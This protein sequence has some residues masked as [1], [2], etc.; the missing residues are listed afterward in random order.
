MPSLARPGSPADDLPLLAVE[1]DHFVTLDGRVGRALACTGLN[2][3][4]QS[5]AA[6]DATAGAFA[7]LL[8]FLPQG[9]RLQ[10][11]AINR[12]LRGADWVAEHL[13]QYRPPAALGDYVRAL[14]AAYE[15][16]LAGRSVPDL[17]FYA[18]LTLPGAPAPRGPLARRFRRRRLLGRDRERHARA[19][20]E[21]ARAAAALEHAFA[22]LGIVAAP[23]GR[24][25]TLDL[26]WSCANPTWSGDAAAPRAVA[27][28]DLRT[29]RERLAQSRLVRRPEWLRLD[30]GYE[31]TL[32]LRALPDETF[33]GWLGQLLATGV[34]FR[35]ALHV[36]P[37]QKS[38]ERAA[39]GRTLR[40]RH[41]ILAERTRQG[42]SPDIEQ[43]EAYEEGRALLRELASTDLRTFRMAVFVTV[44]A[45][46]P[47]ALAA[48][49]GQV[50]RALGDAGGTSIDRCPLWQDRA[51]RA[52]LPLGENPAGNAY[53][54]VT[55]NLADT[56]PFLQGRAGTRGGPLIGF[57]DPGHETV[58]LDPYDPAL[59]NGTLVCLGLGGSGKTL[60]AQSFALKHVALGGRVVVFDRSTGHFDD[61]AAAVGGVVHRVGL[62]PHFRI[63][64]WQLPRGVGAPGQGKLEYLLAL[65][66]LLLGDPPPD[67]QET[68][69]LEGAIRAT[70]REHPAWTP[71]PY[72]R[73]LH[74][75]LRRAASAEEDP[76]RRRRYGA[77]A[78][79]LAPYVGDGTYAA[80]LDGPTTVRP[81]ALAEVFNFKGLPDRL[82]PL[83]MTALLEYIWALIA[84]PTRP[85]LLI[86]DEGWGL[87][88]QPASA[89]FVA[90]VTRTGRHHGLVTLNMSQF[91]ADYD[92]PLGRAVIENAAVS[93]LLTQHDRTLP[94]VQEVFGLSDDELALVARA[95]TVKG[96]GAGAYLHARQGADP[97]AVQLY[98]TPEEY[99]LFTSYPPERELRRAAVARHG[100][101]V[102]AAVR[103][104]AALS[105]AE[106]EA[107]RR[108]DAAAGGGADRRG[109]LALV[110][111]GEE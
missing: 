84:E 62:G 58:T 69:L 30:G 81:D 73:H 31:Q 108:G 64:P 12:P 32:S 109:R 77:L 9:A 76:E 43:E 72:E 110:A 82:A 86:L 91:V 33:P 41:A 54:M 107:L 17:R 93:L 61:L 89:P 96:V 67:G 100:G 59:P 106:R 85:L 49:A 40:Q 35:F 66:W 79:R 34:E 111:G 65:H 98:V 14:G 26:V 53:R 78:D 52:T 25:A 74:A 104:L 68:A 23:L 37:L 92:G 48:A 4:I 5:V 60:F 51:W 39:L 57:A 45:A 7:D 6:A 29:L 16:E 28:G 15:R 20:A 56:L 70:Y 63:N 22:A 38:K 90:E 24:Q 103:E 27:P 42:A 18:V 105:P 55:T 2:L 46:S 19:V 102:W 36:E 3:A 99:W 94:R 97:G 101:D 21:L 50:V 80:L 8:N 11:V 13:A 10:L 75:W 1:E 95:R 83:A 47:E 88:D 87:L 71:G 44:R